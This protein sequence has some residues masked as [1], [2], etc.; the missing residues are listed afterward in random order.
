MGG[1]M[2]GLVNFFN[3][4]TA[5]SSKTFQFK[6]TLPE[7]T[8]ISGFRI[9]VIVERRYPIANETFL[10]TSVAHVFFCRYNLKTDSLDSI[11]FPHILEN[12]FA[13]AGPD[14]N[15]SISL[16]SSVKGSFI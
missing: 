4:L 13:I 7:R 6:P 15:D 1:V 8:I 16:Y 2:N 3:V 11:S 14:I 5:S 9:F 10:T 12:I